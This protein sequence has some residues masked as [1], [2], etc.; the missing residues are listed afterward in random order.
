MDTLLDAIEALPYL[1]PP[2]RLL[3]FLHRWLASG[4][5]GPVHHHAR[6]LGEH[7][8]EFLQRANLSQ[9]LALLARSLIR[10][11]LEGPERRGAGVAYSKTGSKA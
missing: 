6:P 3:T 5:L 9:L 2:H 11:G 7:L 10:L 4:L 8:Q 1:G